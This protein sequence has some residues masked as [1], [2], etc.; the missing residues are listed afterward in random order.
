M[1]L[2]LVQ[3]KQINVNLTGSFS[4]SFTGTLVGTSSW[5]SNVISSSYALSSSYSNTSISSSYALSS[6]FATSASWAPQATPG[7]IDR[8]IQFNSGSTFAGTGS[9]VFNYL[10]QSLE[11][12]KNVIAS[13]LYSH[14][15]GESSYVDGVAA[16]AE[17]YYTSASGDYSHAEGE[18]TIASQTAA[19]AE[20]SY[21]SAK[22]EYS[23]AEGSSTSAEGFASHAEGQSTLA[24]GNY[25]HAEGYKA[26]ASADHSHAEGDR[27]I[28]SG[29]HAH[30]EGNRTLA[31]EQYSH[32]EGQFTTASGLFSHAEG[33]NTL[34]SG[35]GSH[36]EGYNTSASGLYS[37]AEGDRT[38][39]Q[40]L[41]SHAEG[42]QTIAL[43]DYQHAQG[44][45]N[46]AS[47]SP[48]AFIIGNG[49]SDASRSNLVFASGSTFQVTGSIIATQGFTGSLFGTASWAD[50]STSSSYALSSSYTLD[51][52]NATNALT[53]SYLN[54]LNQDVTLNGNLTLNG[55]A[56]IT[57]L[58]VQ[59][60]TA[61]VIYSTGSNQ[62]GDAINDIQTLYGRVNIPTG[63]L[64]VTGSVTATRGFTG[65][66]FG[67]SSW[68]NNATTAT[69]ANTSTTAAATSQVAVTD[70]TAGIGPYYVMFADGATGNRAVRVDSNILTF[71]ATTNTLAVTNLA[72]TASWAANA[73][74]A[75]YVLNAVSSSR[76]VSSSFTSTASLSNLLTVTPTATSGLYPVV[77]TSNSFDGN[78]YRNQVSTFY[79]D[80]STGTLV[81]SYITSSL[82]GTASYATQALSA[83]YSNNS[84]SASYA[85]SSSYALNATTASG[86]L[87]GKAPHIPYFETDTTLATSSLYQSGSSTVIINQDNATSANPEALYVWQPS[88]TSFNVIS[89]KGNLN[90][91]L[92]LNIQNTNNGTNASSD[93][94]ATANNGNESSNY[95]DMGINNENYSGGFI[96]DANDAYLYSTGKHLHIGNASNFP[97]QLFAGG[98]DVDIHN[99]LELNPNNQHTMSGSLEISGSLNVK[100]NLT[101]S[102]ILTNGTNTVL[103]NTVM[104]GSSTIQGTTT[105]TGSVLISGSTTQ[106][107]NN[108]LKG[109]TLLSGSIVISG[110]YPVGSRSSS[111]LVHANTV[112]EGYVRFN[113]V[114]S[115]I[116]TSVSA[117]YV[118]V[119]GSTNDLYFS[120]NGNG[121]ANTTRLRWL[122]GNLY[123]GLLNG[124][125]ITTQSSTV[126]QISSGSGIVV[127]LNASYNDNPYPTITYVNWNN[128]SASIS[129]LSASYDQS[130]VSVQSDGSIYA[131]GTPYSDGQFNTLI[132]IGIVI[133]QN[134]S[135]I[136]AIQTF[137]SVAYGWKQRS[138]DFVRAFGPIKISGYTL[139][140][141]G[142]STGSLALT[143]GTSFVDGRN[144]TVDPNNPS[145]INELTG[146]TTSKIYRYYQSGSAGWVYNTNAGAGYASIDPTQYSNNGVLTPLT[147]NNKWSIQRVYY[148]PNSAT[149][150]FYIYYGNA[151]YDTKADAIAALTTEPFNEAPNTAAN[152]LFIG[153]LLVQKIA[154]FTSAGT[155]EIR[156]G[157]LFRGSGTAIGGGS[158][159]TS[160][161]AGLSDVSL[162][163]LANNNLLTYNS[164]TSK[165]ENVSTVTANVVGNLT[166]TASLAAT[167]S[168][169]NPTFI[170]ASAAASG[171]GSGGG[172]STSGLL[173]TASFNAYT[174]SSISQFAGTASFATTA[175][176][177]IGS[178]TTAA[179]ASYS[180]NFTVA[181]TLILD[182]TLTDFVKVNSTIVG[183]NN[184]FQQTTGS[185]TSAHGKY[186]LLKGANARAGEFITVW[187]G[188]SVTYFDN[189][190]TDI[191]NTSD[192][193][194]QSQV[195]T[196]QIQLN[197]VAASSGWTVKMLVTYL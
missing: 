12:G 114:A 86:I 76:A 78:I 118:Y 8:Q 130:F 13:G 33:S 145:Y 185:Y 29:N 83:S 65:S 28:A 81:T 170:S 58:T 194:F 80:P 41:Y 37:H 88:T 112:H 162:T 70:T 56:S 183:T 68:A 120:Q 30:A 128:L 134:H 123:T 126:Y 54:N 161:L 169:I 135:T 1:A 110:S 38:K 100:N 45:F 122:E 124:G 51:A 94:V 17:G 102:G 147:N 61:S 179:T 157:G 62:F 138:S 74:T 92:Q 64:I 125:L 9:F 108:T 186:T 144:Y 7:G 71:N 16:H 98:S 14:A 49:T 52:L 192:I 166:G 178:V 172:G 150:A 18:G 180:T 79:F 4:G 121:Y 67:T 148:F 187:N 155:Y 93:V 106:I 42:S 182:E 174:G 140:P 104:S 27:T 91:Y 103:G 146:I 34:A 50:R 188:T 142:S 63:S 193:T 32:A 25:S 149:K 60:E 113:P 55:T 171:F 31:S 156:A 96:G 196:S 181:N 43:G 40:G 36:A 159:T 137:P 177:V 77:F 165:W 151:E 167:A 158:A 175:Q 132:P 115:N 95:I 143:G 35:M 136:N 195:V 23:H 131:Q 107:G 117:S 160:T 154:D 3:G 46:I 48:S 111:L 127:N 164:G 152:A 99:K 24:L 11:Q 184:L 133:H 59:Y 87:G 129:P 15:E 116:D 66:L 39:S 21:T 176:N 6:S 10:S 73:I 191:G 109:N 57:Y 19:H 173:T 72:G 5:A 44:A 85:L 197:A 47:S 2:K 190:T 84:T 163:S 90:N 26:T 101:S 82:F 53:A 22:G 97:V 141:S 153:Y 75:S 89:G 168:Y 119:S 20:G 139:S 105:M 69:S 189:S